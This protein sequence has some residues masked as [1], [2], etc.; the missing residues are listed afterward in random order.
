AVRAG[1]GDQFAH[2]ASPDTAAALAVA[3][4]D[5]VLDRVAEAVMG[6][7]W[8]VAGIAN[9][10]LVIIDRHQ[11]RVALLLALI[12]PGL[13]VSQIHRRVVPDCRAVLHGIVVDEEDAFEIGWASVAY[14]HV[15]I[16][17]KWSEC[18]QGA[19]H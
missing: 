7:P 19:E 4:V 18:A 1:T 15:A 9:H 2:Q 8:A 13:A 10:L 16:L 6:S 3:H 14:Q 17:R 11:H 5:R 12:K